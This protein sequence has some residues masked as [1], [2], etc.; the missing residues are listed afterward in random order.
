MSTCTL[1]NFLCSSMALVEVTTSGASKI[2]SMAMDATTRTLAT[3]ELLELILGF[4]G[5]T[6]LFYCQQVSRLI[7]TVIATSRS[8]QQKLFLTAEETYEDDATPPPPRLNPILF[9]PG[10][11]TF[12][13]IKGYVHNFTSTN[14]VSLDPVQNDTVILARRTVHRRDVNTKRWIPL[15]VYDIR[16]STVRLTMSESNLQHIITGVLSRHPDGSWKSMFLAQLPCRIVFTFTA[17]IDEPLPRE[18]LTMSDVINFL[19]ERPEILR[20]LRVK[21]RAERDEIRSQLSYTTNPAVYERKWQIEDQRWE[22]QEVL[23]QS[24]EQQVPQNGSV[25]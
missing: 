20:R 6:S 15:G 1:H 19:V 8:L 23:W 17:G 3:P 5:A 11:R 21:A 16:D 13:G 25:L 18:A 7:R 2:A 4:L 22:A 9:P 10:S 14:V 12:C 24:S